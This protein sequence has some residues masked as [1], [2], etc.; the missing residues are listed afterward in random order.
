[1]SKIIFPEDSPTI[2]S[3]I[4]K[5]HS[6]WEKDQDFVIK[7]EKKE[8]TNGEILAKLTKEVYEE[9]LS[10]S[11]LVSQ[12]KSEFQVTQKT[13]ESIGKDLRKRILLETSQEQEPSTEEVVEQVVIPKKKSSGKDTYREL[14]K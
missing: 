12:I 11:E 9:K 10:F 1:M 6:L 3:D 13:A 7:I 14:I 4:L 2:I 5:K 8:S